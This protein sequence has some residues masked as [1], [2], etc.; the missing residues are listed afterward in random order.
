MAFSF[1]VGSVM[2]RKLSALREQY[3]AVEA[4]FGLVLYEQKGWT[5]WVCFVC[6]QNCECLQNHLEISANRGANQLELREQTSQETH[7]DG[8]V[9]RMQSSNFRI[10]CPKYRGTVG[11]FLVFIFTFHTFYDCMVKLGS[12]LRGKTSLVMLGEMNSFL[13]SRRC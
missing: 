12:Y 13:K 7:G 11:R 2:T 9:L 3:K 6:F 10:K 1:A 4:P 8:K 5:S